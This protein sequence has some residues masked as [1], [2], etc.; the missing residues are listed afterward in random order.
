MWVQLINSVV[1]GIQSHKDT[2]VDCEWIEVND[3]VNVDI[4]WTYDG[5]K[6]SPPIVDEVKE[7]IR[8]KKI[9]ASKAITNTYPLWK[10]NNIL[11]E[12]DQVEI[13]KMRS[14]IKTIRD[15]SNDP[16]L[17]DE[18][19]TILLSDDADGEVSATESEDESVI[20]ES[21]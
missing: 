16:E 8:L 5:E 20:S 6:F 18:D 14:F 4:G 10:Q 12:G 7:S 15:W 2:N 9:K 19:L 21:N 17:T 1:I 11:M 13:D 3:D